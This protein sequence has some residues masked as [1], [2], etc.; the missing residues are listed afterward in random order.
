MLSGEKCQVR[1]IQIADMARLREWESDPR[2]AWGLGTA[3]A[4]DSRESVEQEYDRL[5][6][7]PRVRLLA[8]TA[9]GAPVGFLR[10]HDLDFVSRK[11]T[12]RIFVAPDHQGHGYAAQA[13]A[14]VADYCFGELALHRLGLV[15]RADNM[16]AVA[17][18]ERTGFTVEGRER[19]AIFSH[20]QWVD[21]IHMGLLASDWTAKG[22]A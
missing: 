2:V 11:A 10:L 18:Y 14:L 12:L 17:L 3:S 5:L 19:D 16:R 1:A 4:F 21:F 8:I 22:R 13:L 9:G 15:V 7:T 20:G 6:R